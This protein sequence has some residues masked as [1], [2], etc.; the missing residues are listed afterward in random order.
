MGASDQQTLFRAV[1]ELVA[2]EAVGHR[3]PDTAGA[4]ADG[5]S[6]AAAAVRGSHAG[7]N[8]PRPDL[9][10]ETAATPRSRS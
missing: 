8:Y 4:A 1:D 7:P 3:G 2:A 9:D 5:A 6:P 10:R